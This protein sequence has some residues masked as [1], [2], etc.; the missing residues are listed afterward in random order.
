MKKQTIIASVIA[1]GAVG[2]AIGAFAISAMAQ[3]ISSNLS[4][5]RN[6]NGQT[7]FTPMVNE[8]T[9]VTDTEVQDLKAALTV[10]IQDEYKARAE[11][12]ALVEKFGEVS[13][14]LNLI[15]AETQHIAALANQF[16]I[17]GFDV[18]AD[19]GSQF[20]V[21]PNTLE[22]AYAIGVQAETAN[23]SLY[24]NYLKQDLPS[25]VERVFTNLMNASE[26]H[27][28]TFQSY[29]DGT[30]TSDHVALN[31]GGYRNGRGS[32]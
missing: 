10:L 3:P 11:Y 6:T 13:P 28:S 20:V 22:E 31:Q 16:A 23:I 7:R 17:Y 14:F 30:V 25:N 26:N 29:L 24:E 18:P 21:I 9:T 15:Q 1:S 32:N 5:M 19:N 27:L 12:V 4:Y 2:L 8:V